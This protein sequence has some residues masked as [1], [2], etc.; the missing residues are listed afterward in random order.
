MKADNPEKRKEEDEMFLRFA[1]PLG[2]AYFIAY[3]FMSLLTS[4][5]YVR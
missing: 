2:R 3:I 5:G 1:V 4:L